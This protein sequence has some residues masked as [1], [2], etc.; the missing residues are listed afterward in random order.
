M[1]G[2]MGDERVTTRS[3]EV[4]SIDKDKGLLVLKGP[5]PGANGGMVMV[6]PAVRLNRKKAGMAR[7]G[8]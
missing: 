3:I 6:R 5:V 8:K 7:A 2:H 1:A 4:V